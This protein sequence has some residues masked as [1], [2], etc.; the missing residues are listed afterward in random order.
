MK[1]NSIGLLKNK[2][3]QNSLVRKAICGII[4]AIADVD[5]QKGQW[6]EIKD[7]IINVE[8]FYNLVIFCSWPEVLIGKTAR[9]VF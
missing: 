4:S 3:E 1:E 5:V 9:V 6:V 8:L 2:N 7:I